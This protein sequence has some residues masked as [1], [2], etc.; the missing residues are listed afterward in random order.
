MKKCCIILAEG[1]E[2]I[3]AISII[4]VL[5]RGKVI[6][7]IFY[8]KEKIVTGAHNIK[9]TAEMRIEDL[10]V[11]L[12]DGII[13]PGGMPGAKNLK[14]DA[15]VI[16]TLKSFDN[17]NKLIA[18]ICAAPIV[19]EKAGLLTGRKITS[20]P[21]FKDEFKDSIYVEDLVVKDGN[22]ITSRGPSTAILFALQILKTLGSGIIALELRNSMLVDMALNS[23][24][25][26]E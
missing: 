16:E 5:R 14:E 7:D 3:E 20:F 10:L 26:Q 19:L 8:M 18:A 12:Y 4:D 22:I 15:W 25:A 6:C 1:F 2:E 9:I 23:N 11:D 13:L 17:E 24:K 21:S